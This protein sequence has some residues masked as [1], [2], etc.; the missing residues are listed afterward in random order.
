MSPLFKNPTDLKV[1][2]KVTENLHRYSAKYYQQN[3]P[4]IL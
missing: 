2:C 1:Q 3:V 4:K